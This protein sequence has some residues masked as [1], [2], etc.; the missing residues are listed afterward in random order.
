MIGMNG[1][2][3]LLQ[4]NSPLVARHWSRSPPV[5]ALETNRCYTRRQGKSKGRIKDIV[6]L[7]VLHG[8]LQR[9]A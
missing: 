5:A 9:N 2:P 8:S 4:K 1:S 3:V 6:E 7:V